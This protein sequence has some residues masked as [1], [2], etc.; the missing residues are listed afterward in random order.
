M[1]VV[2]SRGV[3]I[4]LIVSSSLCI[5]CGVGWTQIDVE[6]WYKEREQTPHVV[7]KLTEVENRCNICNA[8][9]QLRGLDSTYY[10]WRGECRVY[11]QMGHQ[12]S[13]VITHSRFRSI[14]TVITLRKDS[15]DTI[16]LK[17]A[18]VSQ[19]TT[20]VE[21][22]SCAYRSGWENAETSITDGDAYIYFK[23][24]LRMDF[25]NV[26]EETGLPLRGNNTCIVDDFISDFAD[27]HNARIDL[28]IE[29]RGLPPNSKKQW[30]P[31]ISNPKPYFDSL[32][33][34]QAVKELVRDTAEQISVD[35]AYSIRLRSYSIKDKKEAIFQVLCRQTGVTRTER[36]WA[37]KKFEKVQLA[38]GPVESGV[39][40]VRTPKHYFV[41]DLVRCELLNVTW[42]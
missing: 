13:V 31:L 2:I 4:A 34:Q 23:G 40:V 37:F 15:V 19:D 16:S 6:K 42:D 18:R 35:G 14:D 26:D 22:I 29:K 32:Q 30:L 17:M 12:W 25:L 24:G 38:F 10:T 21:P 1:V 36:V 41:F 7:F 11:G 27:G 33:S 5:S 3:A 39:V 28:E 20:L 9:V 8:K